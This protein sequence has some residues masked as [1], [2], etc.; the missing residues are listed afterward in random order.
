M[1][2]TILTLRTVLLALDQS[3]HADDAKAQVLASAVIEASG[4]ENWSGVKVVEFTFNVDADGKQVMSA[5]H[6]WDV[7]SGMDTITWNGKTATVNVNV[8]P[9]KVEDKEAYQRWVNDSYWL[10]MPLK[11]KDRGVNLK[12]LG[13]RQVEGTKFQMIELSFGDI[14]MTPNDHYNLYVAANTIRRWDY[15]PSPDKTISGTWEEYRNFNGV[16][17]STEHRFGDKRIYFTDVVV[18]K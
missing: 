17:L 2:K 4:G 8:E 1:R 13:E 15:M 16:T 12:Y 9:S 14:G 18:T 5:K 7:G 10:L 11:L 6:H 3:S